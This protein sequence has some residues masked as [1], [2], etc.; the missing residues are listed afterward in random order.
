MCPNVT[1]LAD[2][3]DMNAEFVAAVVITGLVVVFIGLIL[4]I[5]FVSG[6]GKLF[7][8]KKKDKKSEKVVVKTPVQ[9]EPAAPA[10][11]ADGG[12]E[13]EVVAVIA[14]AVAAMS[15]ESGKKLVIR[16]IRAANNPQR[17]N[18]WAYA[19]LQDNTRP[20]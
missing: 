10:V 19:G 7:T 20:F 14:A 3:I 15:A 11:P 8:I 5:L 16:G 17:R 4:L 12:I 18:V 6:L 1:L 2:N 13:G 9:A